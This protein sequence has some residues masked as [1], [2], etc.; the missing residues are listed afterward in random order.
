[1]M[2]GKTSMVLPVR[3]LEMIIRLKNS[4]LFS[5]LSTEQLFP[6]AD[7]LTEVEFKA[8]EVVVEQG[9]TGD[10]MYLILEGELVA[11][12]DGQ[13]I[14]EFEMGHCFGELAMLDRGVRSATVRTKTASRLAAIAHDD[15]HDL[16]AMYP[17]LSRAVTEI[18]LT[19][20]RELS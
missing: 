7:I 3:Y 11:S 16:L 10:H 13:L 18:L 5:T 8:D 17:D 12:C 14:A 6:L 15:F 4:E 19:R 20:L 1:M 2:D 9:T